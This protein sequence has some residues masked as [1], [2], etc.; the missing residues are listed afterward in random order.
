M[1]MAYCWND[2]NGQ[3]KDSENNLFKYHFIHH[4]S[5]TDRLGSDPR[6]AGK[7]P[8][9]TGHMAQ[10][11]QHIYSMLKCRELNRTAQT[12]RCLLQALHH[13]LLEYISLKIFRLYNFETLL[14]RGQLLTRCWHGT[15]IRPFSNRCCVSGTEVSKNRFCL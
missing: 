9:T 1:S 15:S 11:V 6:L 13:L 8:A 12:V 7:K 10:P 5:H 2:Y 3:L 4:N 14:S